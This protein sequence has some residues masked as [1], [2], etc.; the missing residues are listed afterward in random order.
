[1]VDLLF[2]SPIAFCPSSYNLWTIA[3]LMLPFEVVKIMQSSFI[4]KNVEDSDVL[5]PLCEI[6][7]KALVSVWLWTFLLVS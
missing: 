3:Y 7:F 2:L 1:M 5:W 4:S 6:T